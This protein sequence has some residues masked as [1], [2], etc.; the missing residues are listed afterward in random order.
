MYNEE[1]SIPELLARL[2]LSLPAVTGEYEILFIDDASSDSTPGI[3]RN[4]LEQ[5]KH[6][7]VIRFSRNFGHQSAV[8]AGLDHASGD[9]VVVMDGD[10][11][12]PP[13][14][15][16]DFIEKWKE[17]YDVVYGVRKKRKEGII[18]RLCYY[19]FY[20]IFKIISPGVYMPL[21]SGD[22]SLMSRKVVEKIRLFPESNRY[23]RGI[24]SWV[25][26][27]QASVV[28]ERDR[29]FAGEAKYTF[30]KLFKLA[31]DGV[32]SFSYFPLHLIT[33]TGFLISIL[34]FLGIIVVLYFRIFTDYSVKGF[35]STASI[36]LFLGGLQIL[37]LG[38][39]GEYIG[40]IYD[41]TKK[42]PHY[43]IEDK[44]GF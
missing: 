4:S 20:R 32:F 29:R 36:V 39:I 22:F 27:R 11:Q 33:V 43:I 23:I 12:D 28:Y 5:D 14:V 35:A 16:K 38:I 44:I 3:L 30:R 2:K 31:Y 26:F 7:R 17:G 37:A 9:V 10:L 18:K 13:E 24:R 6:L 42:R 25:G 40:R 8:S 21:D 19:F 15:I 34:S 41:E 1:E